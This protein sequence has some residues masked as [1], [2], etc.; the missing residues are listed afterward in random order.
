MP[1]ARWGAQGRVDDKLLR[2]VLTPGNKCFLS[3]FSNELIRVASIF[4]EDWDKDADVDVHTFLQVGKQDLNSSKSV[5]RDLGSQAWTMLD[6]FQHDP[7]LVRVALAE[8]GRMSGWQFLDAFYSWILLLPVIRL[9]DLLTD[10]FPDSFWCLEHFLFDWRWCG[11]AQHVVEPFL[12]NGLLSDLLAVQWLGSTWKSLSLNVRRWGFVQISWRLHGILLIWNIFF[13]FFINENSFWIA[14]MI[15]WWLIN[16]SNFL[17]LN[18]YRSSMFRSRS[19][20]SVLLLLM[21]LRFGLCFWMLYLRGL[22]LILRSGTVKA[23]MANYRN[24]LFGFLKSKRVSSFLKS[25]VLIL[26]LLDPFKRVL[27]SHDLLSLHS[28]DLR[29]VAAT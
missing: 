3:F 24:W 16:N 26:V 18:A 23:R 11:G 20:R 2:A 12:S 27:L 7:M 14:C 15:K 19:W 4:D 29:R 13:F 1:A 25:S 22:V 17:V 5:S 28:F 21:V 8:Q 9:L 6:K 10:S